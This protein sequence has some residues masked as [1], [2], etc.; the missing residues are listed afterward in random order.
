MN[1]IPTHPMTVALSIA[2]LAL[3]GLYT[4]PAHAEIRSP[5][6][7]ASATVVDTTERTPVGL[8]HRDRLPAQPDQV[9]PEYVLV[10]ISSSTCP[11]ATADRIPMVKDLIEMHRARAQEEERVFVTHGVALDWDVKAGY[12]Y[13]QSVAEFDEISIGQSI[14]NE[15]AFRHLWEGEHVAPATPGLVVMKRD[16][17]FNNGSGAPAGDQSIDELGGYGFQKI[18]ETV[19]EAHV[20]LEQLEEARDAMRDE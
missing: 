4:G 16:I 15:G 14:V 17:V 11:V 2:L 10:F 6:I 1:D 8:T 7:H 9:R 13:L 3:A 20:G 19:E 18:R 5:Q 12:D